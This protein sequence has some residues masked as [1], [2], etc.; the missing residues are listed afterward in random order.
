M[1]A[2]LGSLAARHAAELGRPDH[3]RVVEQA[4]GLQVLD[5][6]RGRLVHAAAHVAVVAG[7]V[8]VAV[9]VAPRKA[10]VGAAPD[11]HEPH[12]PLEQPPGDQAVAAEVLGDLLVEPVQLARR[13]GLAATG[14]A[15]PARSVASR[16]A[17][18]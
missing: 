7:E 11:L 1:I 6:R 18:S 12:A 13:L 10:V 16:A 4:A 3:D 9:P 14:R 8:F 5:Q 15:P 17:S 2:P